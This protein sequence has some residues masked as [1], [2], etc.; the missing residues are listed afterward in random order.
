MAKE[1]IVPNKKQPI[2]K[3]VRGVI[4]GLFFGKIDLM[5][6]SGDIP[7]KCIFVCNHEA[8]MGPMAYEIA[9]PVFNVKW[10]A[11]QML[12][13]YKSRWLYLRDVF[14]MQKKGWKKFPASFV[15]TFEAL[16]SKM[17]YK[18]MKLIGTYTDVRLRTTIKNSVKVLDDNKAITIFPEDSNNGYHTIMTDFFPGFV[19]LSEQYYRLRNEDLPIY[20]VY[21]SHKKRKM[22]VGL[23]VYLQSLVNKGMDR[24]QICEYFKELVNNLYYT[25]FESKTS[26][27]A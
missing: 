5:S 23:P 14:Y 13:N 24:N 25:F 22:V 26:E 6:L 17:I 19:M 20:P 21:Y 3:V 15:A 2:F 4:K 8:K 18:G 12:G 10:G 7:E 11:H 16:F 9:L 1:Y 27:K